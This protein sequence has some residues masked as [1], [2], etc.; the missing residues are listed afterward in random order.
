V[1]LLPSFPPP[2][3]PPSDVIRSS[4]KQT[5]ANP[6]LNPTMPYKTEPVAAKL[7]GTRQS[8]KMSTVFKSFLNTAKQ[9]ISGASTPIPGTP[10]E[11]TE[12]DKLFPKVNPELDGD[13]CDHDCASCAVSFP[14]GF[15]IDEDD[16]LYGHV[17]GW[18]QHI[19]VATGKTDWVRDVADE[20]GSVMEA[21]EKKADV[22]PSNGVRSLRQASQKTSLI[23]VLPRE[24]CFLR[25]IFPLP[26]IPLV[27][28]SPRLSF[29]YPLSQLSRTLLQNPSIVLLPNLSIKPLQIRHH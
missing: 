23:P 20:K 7:G 12:I 24:S 11:N 28:P 2:Q 18:S 8:K 13:D 3:D 19:L 16:K 6:T 4:D 5:E 29:S 27:I 1:P 17:K 22:K 26:L 10:A 21:I 14:K 15:K 25:Q 9:T